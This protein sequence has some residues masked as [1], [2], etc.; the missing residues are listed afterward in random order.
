MRGAGAAGVLLLCAVMGSLWATPAS[1]QI[2]MPDP[3]TISGTP[4]PAAD[5]L[6]RQT[7]QRG[8]SDGLV[9]LVQGYQ[10]SKRTDRLDRIKDTI[11]VQT[12]S[13]K[14]IYWLRRILGDWAYEGDKQAE[15][16]LNQLPV[17]ESDQ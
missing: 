16:L 1:A 6:A 5:V 14:L 9:S 15:A 2:A 7:I 11:A 3:K 8:D 13:R 10:N 12:K 17:V 4:L